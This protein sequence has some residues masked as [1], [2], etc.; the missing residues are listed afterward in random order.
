M[1]GILAVFG[2]I[3]GSVAARADASSDRMAHRGPDGRGMAILPGHAVLCH[4]RLAI[5][6]PAH[7]HQ[8]IYGH[9]GAA[10]VHNGEIYNYRALAEQLAASGRPCNSGSDS[11]VIVHLYELIGEGC[12]ALLDGIFAFAVVQ[13]EE[14]LVARD[15]IGV[16][17][18]YWGRDADGNLWFASELKALVDRC[19]TFSEFPPGHMMTRRGGLRRWYAPAWMRDEP[20]LPS[21]PAALRARLEAAVDKRLMSDV[22]LGVLLSGGLDSSLIAALATRRLRARDPRA[23]IHSFAIGIDPEAPDLRAAREVAAF[24]DTTHHEVLFRVEDG[25]AAL[26]DIVRHIESYDVPTIR[27]SI[28]M[29]F[30]SRYI[31]DQGVKVVLSGEGSDEIFGGYLYFYG[32]ESPEALRRETVARVRDLHL[33]DVLRADKSTMAH[34]VEARVPFLDL[35]FLDLAMALPPELKQPR[36]P[37]AGQGG[38]MEKWVLRAAFADPADPLIPPAVLWRQKEQF[39]DGVGYGWVDGLRDHAARVVS[40][41]A[42]AGAAERFP[43]A[44]PATAEAYLY[45]ERFAALFPGEQAARCVVRWTPRW[46]TSGDTSGRANPLHNSASERLLRLVAR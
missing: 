10:V 18:L 28:P 17:P 43:H 30:L 21:D 1:C 15:P 45:R 5:M 38:R 11:E 37:Q 26:D 22:P 32:A 25:L 27:A 33:S 42:L 6:D 35:E 8:P 46:Q 3:D 16:K 29:F 13:G 20:P 40:A 41:E 2:D 44:T 24:L 14:W 7:G 12:V 4:R 36:R 34:G 23:P 39:S 31:A 19:E 9:A